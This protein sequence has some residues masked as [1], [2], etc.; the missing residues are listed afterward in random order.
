ME[1]LFLVSPPLRNRA[2]LITS[3]S[4]LYPKMKY[5]TYMCFADV[6]VLIS[7]QAFQL[8]DKPSFRRLL[9]YLRPSL[10][11]RDIP[12][13][14]KIHDEILDRSKL[15]LSR[16][17]ETIEVRRSTLPC[18]FFWFNCLRRRSTARC[19]WHLTH[20]HPSMA[21][22]FWELLLTILLARLTIH[23]IGSSRPN[24]WRL[25]Q[26]LEIIVARTLLRFCLRPLMPL[27]FALR[28]ILVVINSISLVDLW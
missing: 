4:W 16:V 21:I 11:E 5:V 10:S 20:G 24:S 3:L 28:Y 17:L 18:K 26:L 19:L 22:L 23:S 15:G 25:R 27:V 9:Q 6:F 8:V 1:S 2:L 7:L 13:R 14:T 12:H